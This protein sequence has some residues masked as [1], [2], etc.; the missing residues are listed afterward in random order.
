VTNVC[1]HALRICDD[2]DML[3]ISIRKEVN[4]RDKAIAIS[5]RRKHQLLADVTLKVWEKVTQSNSRFNALDKLILEV[6]S[7]KM[8]VGLVGG[9]KTNGTS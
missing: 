3:D 9:S 4:M 8:P 5:F 6:H 2:S 1:L 7:V